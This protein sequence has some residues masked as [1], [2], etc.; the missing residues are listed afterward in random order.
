MC[1][2]YEL[3]EKWI[4]YGIIILK[5]GVFIL[6]GQTCDEGTC[7]V[8]TLWPGYRGV[9]SS[10]V[11]LYFHPILTC[12]FHASIMQVFFSYCSL[13]TSTHF[14]ID[15]QPGVGILLLHINLC[16][17]V[18]YLVSKLS[19]YLTCWV[20]TSSSWENHTCKSTA[21]SGRVAGA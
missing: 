11:L 21:S 5:Y 13:H 20:N 15:W 19:C 2:W 3:N 17:L 8:G 10:Q 7:H 1:I 12:V 6:F 18:L 4:K 16:L 14:L 9:P